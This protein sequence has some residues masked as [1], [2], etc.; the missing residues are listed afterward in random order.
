MPLSLPGREPASRKALLERHRP[1]LRE[2]DPVLG[3]VVEHITDLE[4]IVCRRVNGP[5]RV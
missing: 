1:C 2:G 3:A 4:T 5:T